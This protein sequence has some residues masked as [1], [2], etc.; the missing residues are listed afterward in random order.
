MK[1]YITY[2]LLLF[3]AIG[4]KEKYISPVISPVTGYLVV[5]GIINSG[6]GETNITLSRTTK[7]SSQAIQ[8]ETGAKVY[9]QGE[10]NTSIALKEMNTGHFVVSNLNLNST[11]KYRLSIITKDG[12]TYQSDFSSVKNNPPID[13]VSWRREGRDVQLFVN[14]HD[15]NNNTKYYLL[16][17]YLH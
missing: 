11:K 10:D 3:I 2:L 7:L 5:E 6:S 4:C 12:K 13:S 9:V 1:K 16:T 15:P 14:T 17:I 8:Y